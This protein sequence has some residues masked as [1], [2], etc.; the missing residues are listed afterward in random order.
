MKIRL[1]WLRIAILPCVVGL[2]CQTAWAAGDNGALLAAPSS[3]TS[4]ALAINYQGGYGA[5][6]SGGTLLLSLQQSGTRIVGRLNGL[7]GVFELTGDLQPDGR[8]LGIG[9]SATAMFY[10]GGQKDGQQIQMMF[11]EPAADGKL[12]M[13]TA[14]YITFSPGSLP[15]PSSW[16]APARQSPAV[17]QPLSQAVPSAMASTKQ[18]S[19]S[20]SACM[21]ACSQVGGGITGMN[22]CIAKR[23]TP[24]YQKCMGGRTATATAGDRAWA[25][26]LSG[27][28]AQ[29]HQQQ[30]QTYQ[31]QI[32]STAQF[33]RQQEE[34]LN[35]ERFGN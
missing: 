10:F 3:Q 26:R 7:K 16:Q 27:Q 23:C 30:M 24:E 33:S 31:Q 22:Q 2:L 9:R 17:P 8:L 28:S 18:C 29:I 5:A 11:A 15:A 34:R 32:D 25:N 6:V 21:T 14:R 19:Q 4:S 35:K 20:S 13:E 12:N 1:A